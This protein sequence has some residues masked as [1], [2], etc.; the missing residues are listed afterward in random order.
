MSQ[1]KPLAVWFTHSFPRFFCAFSRAWFGCMCFASQC[2]WSVCDWHIDSSST[3][4]FSSSSLV[5]FHVSMSLLR[6][7]FFLSLLAFFFPLF[8]R[9]CSSFPEDFNFLNFSANSNFFL[10][11]S[12]REKRKGTQHLRFLAYMDAQVWQKSTVPIHVK[13]LINDLNPGVSV[14]RL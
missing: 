3:I 1:T 5:S 7:I 8:L 2:D 10:S 13:T 9:Y 4:H 12:K 11:A 14:V 6:G